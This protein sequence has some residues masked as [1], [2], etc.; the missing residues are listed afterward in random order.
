MRQVISLAVF[1]FTFFMAAVLRAD[2][3]PASPKAELT[4][5]VVEYSV[6]G[7]RI[8]AKGNVVVTYKGATLNADQVEFFRDTKLANAQGHVRLKTTQG[9]IS[10]E[11]L[12]FN[13]EKMTG[14]FNNAKIFANP[15]Y[16]FGRRVKKVSDDEIIMRD[17]KLTT[18]D[19]DKPHFVLTPKKVDILTGQK[20]VATGSKFVLG[21]IPL[22]YIPQF[23]QRLDHKKP[24]FLLTPGFTKE[25]GATLLTQYNFYI[26]EYLEGALHLDL[27]EKRGVAEGAD[28]V[29]KTPWMGSGSIKT[30]YMNERKIQTKRF[31]QTGE[32]YPKPI[33]RERFR[34][35]WRHK[36]DIDEQTNAILQY[37]KLSDPD[38]L[39]D[40]FKREYDKDSSP[41]TFFLLTRQ[42]N[43][44]TLSFRADG[45]VNNF[46]ETI[47]R[48]PE[49][50]YDLSSQKIGDTRFYYKNTTTYTNFAHKFPAPTELRLETQRVDSNHELAY[51]TKVGIFEFRPY[52]GEEGTYYSKT[53][54]VDEY[55]VLRGIFRTGAGL[56]TKFYKI[57]DVDTELFG[58][59]IHRLRHIITPSV[60]Y[61]Y[62][63]DPSIPASKLDTFDSIDSL[64]KSDAVTLGLENKLQTKRD[65]KVVDL[66]RLLITS[67]FLL[68]DDPAGGGFSLV[69]SEMDV[70]PFDWLTLYS[71]SEYNA[72]LEHLDTAN[73][74]FYINGA[75]DK[76]SLGL[77][78]RFNRA[79]DDQITTQFNYK[80]NP[81]WRFKIYDRFDIEHGEQKEQNYTLTRDL[82]CWEMDIN[83]SEIRGQ[84]SEILL[85][86]R[87]KAFPEMTTIDVGS[88]FNRRKAGSQSE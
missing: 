56:S 26:N 37:S 65:S 69:K 5:D 12:T 36:W 35:E 85:V 8:T 24:V 76:W 49:I 79:V 47:E 1:I 29:Y 28:L 52:V 40:Y 14:E 54:S 50:R 82:H 3:T 21:N 34:A 66:A 25:W 71:D 20:M 86:F 55:S 45:R 43:P 87:L 72:K 58:V 27:R 80:I 30:Y 51:Q 62:V 16:G 84:G 15:Y 74:D 39:K 88:S 41:Q 44:G 13:F 2:E 9:E 63:H 42:L 19:L 18:C 59:P 64:A 38:I 75:N 4:G 60:S 17:T 77:G 81:L 23:T 53:K 6:D 68:K 31:Y 22:I 57:M 46:V 32:Q 10:G 11:K 83:F 67:D 33:Y 61:N 78:K 48:L 73:F 7:N 70:K